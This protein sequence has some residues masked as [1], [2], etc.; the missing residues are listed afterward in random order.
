[1]IKMKM[2]IKKILKR[3]SVSFLILILPLNPAVGGNLEV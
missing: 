1:M 3:Q 2:K